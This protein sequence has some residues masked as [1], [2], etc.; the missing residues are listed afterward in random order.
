[1]DASQSS[2][3]STSSRQRVPSSLTQAQRFFRA[4]GTNL[5]EYG[6]MRLSMLLL[7][8]LESDEQ[9]MEILELTH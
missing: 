6:Y 4:D 9:P 7:S 8:Q 1:M 3:P 5:N 2:A